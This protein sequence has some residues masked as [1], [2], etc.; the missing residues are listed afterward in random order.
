MFAGLLIAA[1]AIATAGAIPTYSI[2]IEPT[3][4]RIQVSDLDLSSS[5]GGTALD[6][7]VERAKDRVCGTAGRQEDDVVKEIVSDCRAYVQAQVD[8]YM[9]DRESAPRMAA[10]RP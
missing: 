9:A 6:L 10:N 3:V 5:A 7:R 4:G 1:Q 2:P 8:R